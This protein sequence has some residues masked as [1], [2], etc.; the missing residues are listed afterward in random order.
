MTAYLELRE[1]DSSEECKNLATEMITP[2][3]ELS[4]YGEG[5]ERLLLGP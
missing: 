2:E 5:F 3:S 4:W 1:H